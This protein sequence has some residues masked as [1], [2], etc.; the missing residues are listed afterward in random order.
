MKWVVLHNSSDELVLDGVGQY[1]DCFTHFVGKKTITLSAGSHIDYLL[2]GEDTEL[3]FRV[4]LGKG[5]VCRFFCL[6]ASRVG[7]PFRLVFDADVDGDQVSAS[8][9]L[10]GLVG[11]SSELVL[12]AGLSLAKHAVN[13]QLDL[14][15]SALLLWDDADVALVPRLDVACDQVQASHGAKFEKMDQDASFYL[16][17]RG[18]QKEQAQKLWVEW[19]VS[20]AFSVFDAFDE[21][22]IAQLQTSFLSSVS[23]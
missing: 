19:V 6:G 20:S 22:K 1:I 10:Y 12:D 7:A 9:L 8:F 5:A 11:D 2:V 14:R 21:E 18:L 23:F 16:M 3:S 15:Q 4:R 17:S 13:A